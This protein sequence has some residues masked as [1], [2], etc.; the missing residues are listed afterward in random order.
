MAGATR[1]GM[2]DLAQATRAADRVGGLIAV[3]RRFR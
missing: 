2:G 3:R 1:S